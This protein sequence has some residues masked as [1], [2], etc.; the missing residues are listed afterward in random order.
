M[1]LANV[2]ALWLT[3]YE[4]SPEIDILVRGQRESDR[5]F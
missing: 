5:D 2:K 3:D 4:K 1:Q